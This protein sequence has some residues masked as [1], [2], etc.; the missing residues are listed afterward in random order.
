MKPLAILA[1]LAAAI[2]AVRHFRA[3]AIPSSALLLPA[4]LP[5]CSVEGAPVVGS[6]PVPGTAF[7]VEEEYF[8]ISGEG[9]AD[10]GEAVVRSSMFV[11][12]DAGNLYCVRT[13]ECISNVAGD[14][15]YDPLEELERFR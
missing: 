10:T 5:P 8:F 14:Q 6:F 7:M 3:E 1:L 15:H 12:D 11:L 2:L 4:P 9:V 13:V